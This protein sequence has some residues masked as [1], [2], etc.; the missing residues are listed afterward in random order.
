VDQHLQQSLIAKASALSQLSSLGEIG[1]RQANSD[2]HAAFA[3]HLS[4]QTRALGRFSIGL[5]S[6]SVLFQ[7]VFP[8]RLAH[9][10]ASSPSFLNLGISDIFLSICFTLLAL[11]RRDNRGAD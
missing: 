6:G 7:V 8:A 3:I 10:S 11:S 1:L 2:L 9:Q 5:R 4:H